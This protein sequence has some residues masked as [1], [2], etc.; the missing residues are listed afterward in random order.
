MSYDDDDAF[1]ITPEGR[2]MAL[3]GKFPPELPK[4]GRLFAAIAATV[5]DQITFGNLVD[6]ANQFLILCDGDYDDAIACVLSRPDSII[7]AQPSK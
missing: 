5:G 4:Q 3:A 2:R 7:E 1:R 6:L